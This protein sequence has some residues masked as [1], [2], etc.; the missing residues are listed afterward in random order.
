MARS[1]AQAKDIL[2]A[3]VTAIN[4]LAAGSVAGGTLKAVLNGSE[5][6]LFPHNDGQTATTSGA[7][8]NPLVLRLV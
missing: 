7:Y 6:L 5:I 1:L 3:V 8:A 4:A 2:P